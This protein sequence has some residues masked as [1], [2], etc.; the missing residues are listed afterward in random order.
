MR[1]AGF[2]SPG[3]SYLHRS[4]A[5]AK[6]LIFAGAVAVLPLLLDHWESLLVLAAGLGMLIASVRV[7]R[8]HLL[9]FSPALGLILIAGVSW[10]FTD[11]GG[12][13]VARIEVGPF[14]YV[15]RERTAD[16]ALTS[17]LRAM[18]WA[19]SYV[20]LLTTTTSRDLA[21]G[22]DT[23]G[24]P[25]RVSRAVAMTLR[26]WATVMADTGRVADAQRARG[27]DLDGGHRWRGI[28]RRFVSTAVP[29]LFIML[30]RFQTLNFALALRAVGAS[31]KKSRL[32]APALGR[33]DVA[34]SGVAVALL[35]L[36][37]LADR[38]DYFA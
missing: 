19:L 10:L 21:A 9:Y 7:R 36:I 25:D 33:Y 2:Y 34:L 3:S 18:V 17:S 29:T 27:V 24:A 22:L 35:A 20:A 1:D 28:A 4:H 32:Y 37:W 16:Q 31:G 30:K 11:L 38:G 6:I 14:A 23:L 26:L 15:L 5:A 12:P 8:R 13:T